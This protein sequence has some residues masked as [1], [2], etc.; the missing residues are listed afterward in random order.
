MPTRRYSSQAWRTSRRATTPSSASVAQ[1]SGGGR[2]RGG[3]RLCARTATSAVCQ[4]APAAAS[5]ATRTQAAWVAS[6]AHGLYVHMHACM[7]EHVCVGVHV[8][9]LRRVGLSRR[10]ER[11]EGERARPVG[12]PGAERGERAALIGGWAAVGGQPRRRA[13]AGTAAASQIAR[14]RPWAAE[15]RGGIRGQA[16]GTDL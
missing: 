12:L 14:E 8:R 6:R 1:A 3:R 16:S 9:P 4:L 13:E 2:R 15:A 10:A 11:A 5:A 7:I